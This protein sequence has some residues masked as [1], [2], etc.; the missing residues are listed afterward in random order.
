MITIGFS[1]REDNPKYV[2]YLQKTS[3]YK[4]VQ[5]IQKIN[6]GEKSLSQVYNEIINESIYDIVVLVHDDLEFETKNWGDKV[7]KHFK[8]DSEYGVLGLAGTK[9]LPESTQ[10]WSVPSSMY[11]IVNHKNNE[12][13]W[14]SK[15]SNDIGSRIERTIIVDGLFIA[16]D[17]NKIKHRFDESIEGFHFY[18][19]GFCLPNFLD[20]VKVGVMFDVRVTHLSIG[21]TNEKWEENRKQF[22][23][24]YSEKLPID[25][26]LRGVCETFI[27]VHDQELILLFEENKKFNNLYSYQYVFLGDR[28]IDKIEHL[29]NLIVARNYE[30]NLE[31]YPKFT[32]YTGWYLLWKNNLIKTKFINLFEYDIILDKNFPQHQVKFFE[33]SKQIVGYVPVPMNNFHFIVNR[34]WNEHIL[35]S[36]K[37]HYRVDL[38]GFYSNVVSNNPNAIWSSTSNTTF[39]V[40]IF[41]DYMKWFQPIVNDI[42]E[43]KTCGHAHERSIT[44]YATLN[45]KKIGITNGLLQHIQMDSHKT[46]GH[47]V[48]MEDSLNRL[49]NK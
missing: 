49:L 47:Q 10:W 21:E 17:K 30:D 26:N 19:L 33:D 28:P 1:T 9:Y 18:D 6:N 24:R 22:A 43:T 48:N 12:K 34:E 36:I 32:S 39:R 35:A 3:M 4:D 38:L 8:K 45:N 44:Y 23:E 46:Q 11:G 7:L 40:D 29:S 2:D 42:K 37:K 31:Q 13:S 25:I 27:F 41:N 5:I 16:L 15:Y 14:T 20:G